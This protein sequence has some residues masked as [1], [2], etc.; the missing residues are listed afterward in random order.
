MFTKCLKNMFKSKQRNAETSKKNHNRIKFVSICFILL[1][2]MIL[3]SPVT[4]A[5]ESDAINLAFTSDV[6]GETG[7][8]ATWID[9][10]HNDV[11]TL[12]R[13]IFGGDY[14]NRMNDGAS[15]STA[16][17]CVNVVRTAYGADI[18]CVL[19]Q[20]NHDSQFSSNFDKGLVYDADYAVYAMDPSASGY[21][22][23]SFNKSDINKLAEELQDIGGS[24]PVFVVSHFPIHF[25]KGN[26][27]GDREV[28]Y[29]DDLLTVLNDHENVIFLWG[30]N[31]TIGDPYYGS[32]MTKGFKI[33]TR[34]S[35]PEQTINFTYLAHGSMMD[36]NNG[37]YGL[38][39]SMRNE[40]D[41]WQIDFSYR[42]LSGKVVSGG[43]VFI[44]DQTSPEIKSVAIT[45]ITAPK[46]GRTP[47][48][49]AETLSDRYTLSEVSWRP[50]DSIFAADTAYTAIITLTPK[51]SYYFT[52]ST[53][54]TIN[55][56]N[57]SKVIPN[58]DNSLTVEY[59]FPE[60]KTNTGIIYE[61]ADSLENGE[62]Y[63]I[64]AKSGD[65]YFALNNSVANTNF[66]EGKPVTVQG[67]ELTASSV[68]G[69]A[70]LWTAEEASKYMYLT[71][72]GKYLKRES[73]PTGM[74]NTSE[75]IP[76]EGYGEWQYDYNECKLYTIST[77][78]QGPGTEYLLFYKSDEPSYF[79]AKS[80]GSSTSIY[81]YKLIN[82]SPGEEEPINNVEI[83]EIATPKTGK[84][85]DISAETS[86]NKYTI[87]EVS[88]NPGHSPFEP[89]TVYTVSLT[90]TAKTNYKFTASTEAT[91]N[92]KSATNVMLNGDGTLT[93]TY[94]FPKTTPVSEITYQLAN[95]LT[96]GETYVIVDKSGSNYYALNNSVVNG[97]Y[98]EG[99]SVTVEDDTVTASDVLDSML[100]TA[101][102]GNEY[103][104]LINDNK[105]LQR[106]SG[107][108]NLYASSDKPDDYVYVEW[109]YDAN[110]KRLYTI[111]KQSN[112]YKYSLLYRI[113]SSSNYFKVDSSADNTNIYLYKLVAIP[114]TLTEISI[115]K[116][117]D[118]LLYIEGESFN[119]A[120]MEVT[121]HYDNGTTEVVTGYTYTPTGGLTTSDTKI[122]V[123]YG[124]K[125]AEAE[126]TVKPAAS[127]GGGTGGGGG[128]SGG[129][130][131]GGKKDTVIP[132]PDVPKADAYSGFNDVPENAW[133]YEPVKFVVMEGIFKGISNDMF[134]PDITIT[135]GMFVTILSRLEFGSDD[136]VPSGNSIFTDLTQDWYKN[137]VAWAYQNKIV[138]GITDTE[139]DPDSILTREQMAVLLYRYAQY[140]GYD[141]SFDEG[142]LNV[143]TDGGSV[144]NYARA[145]MM[146]SIK[147][148]LITGV[149][150]NALGPQD[151]ATRAQCS[152]KFLRL[153][154]IRN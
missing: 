24:K 147:N 121:A 126:I 150:E 45:G 49:S 2:L 81:I 132:E 16:Q 3:L 38:L 36:G 97:D 96:A 115:T 120:G 153:V 21:S 87:S 7:N 59:T 69:S 22:S 136:K 127:T 123:T 11:S 62:T 73:G 17:E 110:A 74:L 138:L 104:Y 135:R 60:T 64:V 144:S 23:W 90:L 113:G 9:K 29:A 76:G 15:W 46:T 51:T 117:P 134:G 41:G 129:S 82:I 149:S 1:T 111:S 33:K 79:Q 32:V 80:S 125:T 37:A 141:I 133:Y 124:G 100:W 56:N 53:I 88:W 55:G 27:F 143:F 18:P 75:I 116:L 122:T 108:D 28:G 114:K 103:M 151:P 63:V 68:T 131:S 58:D 85:P 30:H 50:A 142:A 39:A 94:E 34:S 146:W 20:G 91:V 6:H 48:T 140:K 107:K 14:P 72:D 139:F 71:N 31:H 66:L 54:A 152:V 102:A 12:D 84:A 19:V 98:L 25:C 44:E 137:A 118:K 65:E 26:Q 86:S 109:Q 47:D 57:A 40:S 92:G 13:M 78:S 61:L 112:Q 119:P 145:G 95:E 70:M 130:G 83:T 4:L 89:D 105:Y 154:A 5:E 43:S 128:G 77:S 52:E 99:I 10:L 106:V 67:N 93:I 8:L 148:G 101:E 42:N 35:G